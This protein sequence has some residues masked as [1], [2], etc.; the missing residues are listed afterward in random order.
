MGYYKIKFGGICTRISQKV[1]IL[2]NCD[3]ENSELM[4]ENSDW[5][6]LPSN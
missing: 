5:N 6:I 4:C 3:K 1:K 2:G